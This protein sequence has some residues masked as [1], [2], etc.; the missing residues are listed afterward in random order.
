MKSSAARRPPTAHRVRAQRHRSIYSGPR[1]SPPPDP[2]PRR[3][4]GHRAAPPRPALCALTHASQMQ[5][6]LEKHPP[7]RR[8]TVDSLP[9]PWPPW[10][11]SRRAV[12]AKCGPCP[13]NLHGTPR[14]PNALPRA[15]A[16]RPPPSPS[17]QSTHGKWLSTPT[18][19]T[20]LC[21]ASGVHAHAR[22]MNAVASEPRTHRPRPVRCSSAAIW[23]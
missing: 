15:H 23:R 22:W 8:P 12:R 16:E 6:P 5:R 1:T 13:E 14:A 4:L 11:I 17:P 19:P 7:A 20:L 21:D 2:G 9:V 10:P 3:R 18:L